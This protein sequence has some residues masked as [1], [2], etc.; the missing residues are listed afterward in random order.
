MDQEQAVPE[1][2]IFC[3]LADLCKKRG[4]APIKGKVW[5]VKLD[6]NWWFC[7]NGFDTPQRV[8]CE[9]SGC[10]QTVEPFTCFVEFN[11]WPAGHFD[12]AGGQFAA[13]S[14]ANEATFR[15]AIRRHL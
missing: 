15:A 3:L 6:E 14:L 8:Q 9:G 5:S 11:G 2:P 10:E 1:E 13:G 7:V 4:E 12:P